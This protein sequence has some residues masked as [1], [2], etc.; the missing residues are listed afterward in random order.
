[1]KGLP[2]LSDSRSTFELKG[3]IVLECLVVPCKRRVYD[4]AQQLCN[5]VAISAVLCISLSDESTPRKYS[6][7]YHMYSVSILA[8]G[9]F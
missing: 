8:Y 1:M 6:T 7:H 4:G 9:A 2:R 3:H 5:G